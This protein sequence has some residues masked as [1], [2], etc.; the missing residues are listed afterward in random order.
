M[1][2]IWLIENFCNVDNSLFLLLPV[3]SACEMHE[4]A[5]FGY[6]QSGG[7]GDFKIANLSL[8]PFCRKFGMFHR[9]NA[10]EAA[11]FDPLL[12]IPPASHLSRL[13]ATARG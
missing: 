12:A 8:Q 10:T 9:K 2:F 1:Q 4:A 7:L 5:R 3:Q 11:T 6:N 13:P